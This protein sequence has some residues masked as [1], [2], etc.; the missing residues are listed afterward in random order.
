MEETGEG[1]LTCSD[2]ALWPP[3][4]VVLPDGLC[5]GRHDACARTSSLFLWE[6]GSGLELEGSSPNFPR[7]HAGVHQPAADIKAAR[8][9][10]WGDAEL[11]DA[12]RLPFRQM[13]PDR[14]TCT[15][16]KCGRLFLFKIMFWLGS[17]ETC[18]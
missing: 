7:P 14:S 12:V 17:R 13:E 5:N 1:R 2:E 18:N 9:D 8:N 16:P 4:R 15:S 3:P 6:V 11:Q 10:A